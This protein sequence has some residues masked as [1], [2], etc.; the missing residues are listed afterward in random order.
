MN[1]KLKKHVSRLKYSVPGVLAI[2][3]L[4]GLCNYLINLGA[5]KYIVLIL[6]ASFLIWL[7]YGALY[8]IGWITLEI[9]TDFKSSRDFKKQK[10]KYDNSQ[11]NL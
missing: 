2:L 5:M 1:L 7:F 8:F 4:I 3:G 9:V 11:K 6:S 10:I